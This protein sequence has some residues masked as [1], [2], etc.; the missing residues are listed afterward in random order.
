MVFNLFHSFA[1]AM[2]L[3]TVANA[4]KFNNTIYVISNAETPSLHLAGLTPVGAQRA[5]TCLPAVSLSH[6][7]K[8]KALLIEYI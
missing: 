4:A 6:F 1:F 7:R 3:V 8:N 5:N 2:V